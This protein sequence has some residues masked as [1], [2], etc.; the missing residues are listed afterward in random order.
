MV[1]GALADRHP[2]IGPIVDLGVMMSFLRH[3]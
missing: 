2:G 3:P 1:Y